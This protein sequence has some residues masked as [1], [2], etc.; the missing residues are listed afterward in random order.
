MEKS[1]KNLQTLSKT[2]L[3]RANVKKPTQATYQYPSNQ[4]SEET[5]QEFLRTTTLKSNI[6]SLICT[7]R[8]KNTAITYNLDKFFKM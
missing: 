8:Y 3:R 2:V 4:N 1:K 5:H 7:P 6:P